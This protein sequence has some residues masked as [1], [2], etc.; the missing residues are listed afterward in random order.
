MTGNY[1]VEF[2]LP[3]ILEKWYSLKLDTLTWL[4]ILPPIARL[5]GPALRR[6]E[7]R[8]QRRSGGCTR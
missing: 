8:P 5:L 2:F 4:V 7:L 6:L 1:G 3:S